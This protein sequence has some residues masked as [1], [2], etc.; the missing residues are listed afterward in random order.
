MF[1]SKN[2]RL[3]KRSYFIILISLIVI[4]YFINSFLIYF[5]NN[6][7]FNFKE[8]TFYIDNDDNIDSLAIKLQPYLKSTNN[9]IKVAK[10]KGYTNNIKSGKYLIKKGS[11]NNDIINNLRINRLTVK[12]VF[13][14]QER[15]EDLASRV[16]KQIMADSISLIKSFLDSE[17][18][19]SR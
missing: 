1:I 8:I 13:N 12:V 4:V 15:L 16:S 6:T 11:S 2:F 17:V 10:K 9:F 14:N 5:S 19:A 18:T 7:D 3:K